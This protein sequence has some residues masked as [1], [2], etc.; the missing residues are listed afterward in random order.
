[1]EYVRERLNPK[2]ISGDLHEA[3]NYSATYD[4]AW[5]PVEKFEVL[6]KE[7]YAAGEALGMR[8]GDAPSLGLDLPIDY[9]RN[10]NKLVGQRGNSSCVR[11]LYYLPIPS[12]KTIGDDQVRMREHTDTGIVTLNFQDQ[13]GGLEVKNPE[14]EFV[15]VEPIPGTVVVTVND[16]LQRWTSGFLSATL[17][18]LPL[19]NDERRYKARQALLF[20][21]LPD[22]DYVYANQP[23]ESTR[24]HLDDRIREGIYTP[25]E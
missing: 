2:R 5:P 14:G 22:D 17:H 20:F 4:T 18:R 24:E 25:K 21:L 1:M 9:M 23:N 11:T 10:A 7:L 6:S 8:V 13:T 12:D 19:P 15:M 3:F 16:S